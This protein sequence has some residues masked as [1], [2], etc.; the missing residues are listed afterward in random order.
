MSVSPAT[1]RQNSLSPG[2][3]PARP[4]PASQVSGA[5]AAKYCAMSIRRLGFILCLLA[6]ARPGEGRAAVTYQCGACTL[7]FDDATGDLVGLRLAG[8]ANW[9]RPAGPDLEVHCE[10][11][12]HHAGSGRLLSSSLTRQEGAYLV[13]VTRAAGSWRLC[14]RYRVEGALL[15]RQAELTWQGAEAVKVIG[16]VLRLPGLVPGGDPESCY[17]LPA[18]YPPAIHPFSGLQPGRRVGES[19][20]VWAATGMVLAWSRRA[21]LAAGYRLVADGCEAFVTE[22][23]GSI[24]LVHHFSTLGRLAPGESMVIGE[25]VIRLAGGGRAAAERNLAQLAASLD[26]GPPADRPAWAAR[27]A[28]YSCHPGGPIDAN[29]SGAGGLPHL[30]AR[31]PYLAHLGFTALWLNPIFTSPPWIYSI[32]DYR[33]L[34]PE[35]GTRQDLADFVC[36]AHRHELRVLLD[37]VP[38]GPNPDTPAAREAPPDAWTYQEDGQLAS[39]WGGLAGDHASPA[40]QRY[41]TD[42]AT[43]WVREFGVDGYRVDCAPGNA[44]NWRRPDGRRPSLSSPLGG[45]ELLA[46]VRAG[47]RAHNPQAALFPEA[48]SPIWFRHGDLVYDYSFYHV[49]RRLTQE[50]PAAWVPRAAQW[51]QWQRLTL[52]ASALP[53][54]VR[55]VENHDTV[56]SAE[57]FGIGPSQ[58]LTALCVFA[59]GTPLIY[60]DQEIGFGEELGRWL[61]LRQAVPELFAGEADYQ[62]VRCSS[63]GVFAFLRT[64]PQG[65]AVVAVSLLPH[66]ARVTLRWPAALAAAF[67]YAHDAWTHRLLAQG[68]RVTLDLPAYRP[69]VLLLRAGRLRPLAPPAPP[70]APPLPLPEIATRAVG[71]LT[72]YRL[73]PGPCRWW[74]VQSGEGLLLDELRDRHTASPSP[75]YQQLWRPLASGFWDTPGPAACGVVDGHGRLLT[76]AITDR[77]RLVDARLEDPSG[78]GKDIALVLVA[79]GAAPPFALRSDP[80]GLAALPCGGP[81]PAAERAPTIAVDPLRVQV[82]TGRLRLVLLRRQGGMIGGWAVR[83]GRR[84]REVSVEGGNLYT[85]VGLYDDRRVMGIAL[86]TCP[87]RQVARQ[88]QAVAV[89]FTGILRQPSWN[90]VQRGWPAEPRISYRLSYLVSGS[91]VSL[92]FALTPSTAHPQARAFFGYCLPLAGVREWWADT[93]AG[94]LVGKADGVGEGRVFA[95]GKTPL[96]PARPELG[97]E[98]EGTRLLV[99]LPAD[100]ALHPQNLFLLAG[101]PGRLTLFAA[102]LDGAPQ[103]LPAGQ[104]HPS[105]LDLTF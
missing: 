70:P 26:N 43:W 95:T 48:W 14:T 59:Q 89:T 55:F 80:R 84:W 18:N 62:A 64:H 77:D 88:G 10:P 67:P 83:E 61:R 34:A 7:D 76:L 72:E 32:L 71:E 98:L 101:G 28:L 44:P 39:A 21:S 19:G 103:D 46:A 13:E 8:G 38:H 11:A 20:A 37:L 47:I 23:Q 17:L 104:E 2:G 35:V 91:Q 52:P 94:R 81:R 56:R 29:F 57:L 51:L 105:G 75:R 42:V 58:A 6:L 3:I 63:A 79:R 22:G 68:D 60:Q 102:S 45:E 15:R 5:P 69:A 25:Q 50:S 100:S 12:A 24:G 30:S 41:I 27:A 31:L 65:A 96:S 66:D 36:Q 53:G 78:T 90:A 1:N 85:D 4:P 82:N 93:A 9:L 87:R 16:T 40:W 73:Q 97:L 33:A 49:M 74:F 54:L 99:R 92:R 86:E